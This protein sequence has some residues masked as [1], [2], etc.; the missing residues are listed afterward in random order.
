MPTTAD[1]RYL[2]RKMPG[3]MS[4]YS[5]THAGRLC[6][7]RYRVALPRNLMQ[8]G[9]EEDGSGL[10]CGPP[11]SQC[12]PIQAIDLRPTLFVLLLVRFSRAFLKR[13][14]P[15]KGLFATTTALGCSHIALL[16]NTVLPGM[17]LKYPPRCSFVVKCENYF[18]LI[19]KWF[20]RVIFW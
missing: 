11:G 15:G 3:R 19:E 18:V 1:A 2:A 4:W 5:P 6:C 20:V 9:D 16:T 14:A 12:T 17:H 8:H 10:S 13:K 7:G